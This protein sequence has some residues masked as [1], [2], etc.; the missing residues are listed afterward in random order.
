MSA[1]HNAHILAISSLNRASYG[2]PVKM[3]A[4]KESGKIEYTAD[5][6]LG[7][8]LA[9][10]KRGRLTAEQIDAE[11]KKQPREMILQVLK[12]R[13]IETRKTADLRYYSAYNFFDDYQGEWEKTRKSGGVFGNK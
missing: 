3:D 12:G 6:V 13:D 11:M 4:F 5:F 7:L 10:T 2:E 8:S 1:E 9:A